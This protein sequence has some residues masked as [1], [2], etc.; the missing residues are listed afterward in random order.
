MDKW[1]EFEKTKLDSIEAWKKQSIA[2]CVDQ[3]NED[4]KFHP[5][6]LFY[7]D[8]K[9]EHG[10]MAIGAYFDKKDVLSQLISYT[11][12]KA[13]AHAILFVSESWFRKTTPEEYKKYG[14]DVA[15]FSDKEEVLMINY[16]DERK[17]EIIVYDIIRPPVREKLKG[18]SVHLKKRDLP[19]SVETVGRFSNLLHKKPKFSEN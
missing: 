11:I 15:R 8:D 16:E 10:Y 13:H 19:S 12:K 5:V 6:F 9:K 7:N 2:F 18:K 17:A 4:G 14:G 3:F 1:P